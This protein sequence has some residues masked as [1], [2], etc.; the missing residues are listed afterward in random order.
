[1]FLQEQRWDELEFLRN[2]FLSRAEAELNQTR[3]A[4]A[5]WRMAGREAEER[6]GLGP[7][8]SLLAMASSWGKQQAREDLLWQIAQ[9][10]PKERWALLDLEQT[11]QA[12]GNTLGLNKVY[13]M[14]FRYNPKD[15]TAQN[16]FAATSLLLRLNLSQAHE[17]AKQAFVQHSGDSDLASTYAYSLHLRGR[18]KEGLASL[19]K[20]K[21]ETLEK[22]SVALYYGLLLSETGQTNKAG[23]YLSIAQSSTLLPEEKVLLTD[24]LK[25]AKPQT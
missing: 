22:P 20:L 19:E 13:S 10:F 15:F 8:L 16:N 5:R 7:L 2:A 17:L 11:Y 24:A 23:K 6:L 3:S 25:K 4:D 14:R 12:A 1:V 18:T 9:R 21:P